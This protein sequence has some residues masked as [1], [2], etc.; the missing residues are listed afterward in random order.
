[1]KKKPLTMRELEKR[2]DQLKARMDAL[3]QNYKETNKRVFEL[4]GKL[5]E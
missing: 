3:E 4:S 1:M 2:V 5:E